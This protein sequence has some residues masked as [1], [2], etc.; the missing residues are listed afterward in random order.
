[1]MLHCG[2]KPVSREQLALVE[3]P[4]RTETWVPVK[5]SL[6][7][8]LVAGM[9]EQSGFS[10]Q[11]EQLG[12]ARDRHRFFGTLDLKSE[13]VP[14]ITLAVGVRNS[15]DQSFP[16]GFCAGSR[17]FVCD[18]LAFSSELIVKRKHT[19]NG[20][21][22]FREAISLA[23]QDLTQFQAAETRRI[24]YMQGTDL[25][26]FE[27]EAF[28]LAAFEK[29][30]LSARTLPKAID[31]YRTP[32]FDWGPTDRVWHLFNAMNL[33]MQPQ[34]QSNPQRFALTTMRLM[35]LLGPKV[36]FDAP[37]DIELSPDQYEFAS[38]EDEEAANR[39][40]PAEEPYDNPNLGI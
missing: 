29:G 37:P 19:K 39:G 33:A 11:R 35:A 18:N 27:A 25:R 28:L 36:G 20:E 14:G 24:E 31:A 3:P 22:R 9:L 8:D 6:V 13:L 1:M 34:N 16:L 2:A 40:L 12:L 5:H 23:V 26:P 15:T 21:L 17:T 30:I 4:P 7:L 32:A 10:I 38:G